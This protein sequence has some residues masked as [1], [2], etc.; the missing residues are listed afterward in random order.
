VVDLS[1]LDV[2]CGYRGEGESTEPLPFGA[3]GEVLES[4]SVAP[5]DLVER[6]A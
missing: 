1:T 4:G 6:P 5:G 2:V 3:S